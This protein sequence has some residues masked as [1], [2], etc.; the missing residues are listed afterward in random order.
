[1]CIEVVENDCA[2][3]LWDFQVQPDKQMVANI[4]LV[5][6]QESGAALINVTIQNDMRRKKKEGREDVS[7]ENDI[8]YMVSSEHCDSPSS[9]LSL[10]SE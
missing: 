5:N 6:N 2:K 3:I 4:M 7:S 9:I 10:S 8:V 1:M